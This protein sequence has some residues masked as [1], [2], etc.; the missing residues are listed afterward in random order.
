MAFSPK[1]DPKI[2]QKWPKIAPKGLK[3]DF[4]DVLEGSKFQ[5]NFF[6]GWYIFSQ[7]F[8]LLAHPKY[9]VSAFLGD[10]KVIWGYLNLWLN[11][12][13]AL[14]FF[15]LNKNGIFPTDSKQKSFGEQNE[16]LPDFL[17]DPKQV[18]GPI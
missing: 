8:S 13:L 7:I 5:E 17:A 1:N 14:T 15:Q 3:N 4:F 16:L 6:R 11:L 2:A 18:L 12:D 10:F 9:L